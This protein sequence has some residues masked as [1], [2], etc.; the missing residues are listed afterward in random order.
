MIRAHCYILPLEITRNH[1][2]EFWRGY[3]FRG[4]LKHLI[5][6]EFTL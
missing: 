6:E 1:G 5:R 3:A 4:G 2:W